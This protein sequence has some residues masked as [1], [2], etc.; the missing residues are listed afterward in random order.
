MRNQQLIE[1]LRYRL[2]NTHGTPVNVGL[3]HH[4]PD[5]FETK[6][7]QQAAVLIPIIRT[8]ERLS[9]F[10]TQRSPHISDPMRWCF[11]GGRL[12][13]QDR[14]DLVKTALR[15]GQEEA[16]IPIKQLD[17]LGTLMPCHDRRNSM[18]TPV[19]AVL[20]GPF[21]PVLSP[22]EVMDTTE[23]PLNDILNRDNHTIN[24]W[25]NAE[26]PFRCHHFHHAAQPNTINIYGITGGIL[27]YFRHF[28]NKETGPL[29]WSAEVA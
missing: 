24:R 17:I 9:V 26:H 13:E 16:G 25:D 21:T 29:D 28:T 19:V 20:D 11:P 4:L 27:N 18:I 15:E 7:R 8:K 2:Q 22:N 23:I 6:S 10:F 1:D 12:E 3:N 14:K 5:I